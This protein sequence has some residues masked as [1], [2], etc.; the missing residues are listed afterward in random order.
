MRFL[1]W[2][3]ILLVVHV[4]GYANWWY[5]PFRT[6]SPFVNYV[7]MIVVLSLPMVILVLSFGVRRL[8]LRVVI[9][10]IALPWALWCAISLLGAAISLGDIVRTGSDPS[11]EYLHSTQ[12]GSSRV[13]V[14]RTNGGATTDYGVVFRHER[15]ILPGLR[16]MRE[17]DGFY[18]CYDGGAEPNN[19]VA[20]SLS[21]TQPTGDPGRVTPLGVTN[22]QLK[23][24]VVF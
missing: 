2:S 15:T 22:V 23:P 17:I 11:C 18:H 7:V 12:T 9:G 16:V 4:L 10:L 24:Y 8:A 20:V 1:R 19:E 14:Y 3:V 21:C 13:S 6:S 5:G